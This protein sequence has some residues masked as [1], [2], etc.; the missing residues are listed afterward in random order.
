MPDLEV[1]EGGGCGPLFSI[2][3]E[4]VAF[5]S[6][7]PSEEQD[8][9]SEGFARAYSKIIRLLVDM[10]IVSYAP[11][12]ASIALSVL[13]SETL[14]LDVSGYALKCAVRITSGYLHIEVL[15]IRT[16]DALSSYSLHRLR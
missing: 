1:I 2:S 11:R 16:R 9:V 7:L 13:V 6:M 15:T 4:A 12:D 10:S 3:E 8:R 5:L 14:M